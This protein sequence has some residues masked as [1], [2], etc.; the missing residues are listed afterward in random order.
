M[1]EIFYIH[2]HNYRDKLD[3]SGFVE[4]EWISTEIKQEPKK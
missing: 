1:K 4:I 2:S 3:S